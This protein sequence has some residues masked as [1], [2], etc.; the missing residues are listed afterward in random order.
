M[1]LQFWGQIISALIRQAIKNVLN[2]KQSLPLDDNFHI[3]VGA[4]RAMR[5]EV[6]RPLPIVILI[7]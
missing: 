7:Q 2:S 4:I 1:P 3:I 5:G 6:G